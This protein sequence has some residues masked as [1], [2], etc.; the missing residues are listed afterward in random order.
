M[1][2]DPVLRFFSLATGSFIAIALRMGS[3]GW[4]LKK[5]HAGDGLDLAMHR[6]RPPKEGRQ[7]KR[8]VSQMPHDVNRYLKGK[9]RS[10]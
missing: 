5:R 7:D 1:V 4:A 3:G 8:N 6:N 9:K 10:I 2:L